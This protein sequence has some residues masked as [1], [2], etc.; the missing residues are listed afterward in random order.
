MIRQA[1]N[2]SNLK[3]VGHDPFTQVLEIEFHHGGIYQYKGVPQAVFDGLLGAGSKGT[4]F[5]SHIK[6]KYPYTRI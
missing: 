6:D 3:S 1:V 4:Y 2:S 5:H